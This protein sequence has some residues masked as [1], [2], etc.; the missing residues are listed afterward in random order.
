MCKTLKIAQTKGCS[1]T[2]FVSEMVGVRLGLLGSPMAKIMSSA[3]AQCRD[4]FLL[5]ACS[6]VA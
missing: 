3:T 6:E 2:C 4:S 5:S 1:T